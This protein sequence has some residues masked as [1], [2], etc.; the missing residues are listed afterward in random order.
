MQNSIHVIEAGQDLRPWILYFHHLPPPPPFHALHQ[1]RLLIKA[2]DVK[3]QIFDPSLLC[4][5][6]MNIILKFLLKFTV[7]VYKKKN[8][9]SLVKTI[10]PTKYSYVNVIRCVN[11][12][13]FCKFDIRILLELNYFLRVKIKRMIYHLFQQSVK[14][15]LNSRT[16]P[17]LESILM[18]P[19]IYLEQV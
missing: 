13:P 3:K 8:N 17:Q 5:N 2:R 14:T 9:Q 6:S 15:R 10:N 18:C 12:I 16:L 7:W 19:R 11:I 1:T 4:L